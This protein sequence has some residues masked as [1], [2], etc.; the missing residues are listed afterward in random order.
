LVSGEVAVGQ[1]QHVRPQGGQ[2]PTGE[3]V[4]AEL[5]NGVEGRIDQGM[6]TAFRQCH[7]ADLRVS[8]LVDTTLA[9]ETELSCVCR[10]VGDIQRGA[11]PGD[12]PQ[13]ES[14]RARSE[15]CGQR[16]APPLEQRLQR[17]VAQSLPGPCQG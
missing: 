1:Q 16:A 9:G 17:F 6:G 15:G 4:L 12:Q 14:E 13:P 2:Q 3:L 7:Q 5:R 8:A 10:G 11:V